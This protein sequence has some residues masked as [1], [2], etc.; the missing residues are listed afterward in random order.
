[1]EIKVCKECGLE[2]CKSDFPI[3]SKKDDTIRAQCN[4]CYRRIRKE[5]YSLNREKRKEEN[6]QSY[7]RHKEKRIAKTIEYQKNNIE[8]TKEWRKNARIKAGNE[9]WEF[10]K[11]LS[12]EHCGESDPIC[13]DFHHENPVDKKY[14]INKIKRSRGILKT[15]LEKCIVLC[16][17]CHRKYHRK[18]ES[19][20]YV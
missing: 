5:F 4:D 2:K 10:K 14:T 13:L 17:N 19:N 6:K 3:L 16:A 12:C 8:R 11:T 7:H 9:F 20:N 15:E 18:I 1:M